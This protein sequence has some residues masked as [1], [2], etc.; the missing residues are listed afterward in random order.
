MLPD[1]K[2]LREDALAFTPIADDAWHEAVVEI[3]DATFAPDPEGNFPVF[4]LPILNLDPASTPEAL[5]FV[6]SFQFLEWHTADTLPDGFY[7]VDAVRPVGGA[8]NATLEQ[9]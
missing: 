8:R 5:L 4:A 1:A 2:F 9:K 7:G 6:D 3:P